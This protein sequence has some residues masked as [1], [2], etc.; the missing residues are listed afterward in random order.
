MVIIVV[1]NYYDDMDLVCTNSY[2]S[3]INPD[4]ILSLRYGWHHDF[5]G[6]REAAPLSMIAVKI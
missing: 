6:V 1:L 2:I 3:S 4:Q 5:S